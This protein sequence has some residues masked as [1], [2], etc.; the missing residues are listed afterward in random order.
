MH[1]K[2]GL[3][4]KS[5]PNNISIREKL[6]IA[7]ETGYDYLE[8]SIDET[9]EKQARLEWSADEIDALKDAIK[10]TKVPIKSI[11][12]SGHRK[13]PLGSRD[14]ATRKRSLEIMQK[15]ASLAA[16]LGI[17]IIQLAGYD[18]YYE[19]SGEDTVELFSKNLKTATEMAA[20]EGVLLGFETMETEFLNTV[21]KTM[22]W[23]DEVNSPYLQI[24]PD[25]GNL[26]NAAKI[27]ETDPVADLAKG[28]GHIVAIHLKETK[29]DV[30]REV[31]YGE[32]H[33]DFDAMC[34]QSLLMGVR[35]FV[36]EFW[37]TGEENWREILRENN[38][39]LRN[40]LNKTS[41]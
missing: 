41:S 12:L 9:D 23:V 10:E 6:E 18:V 24:Y 5:M 8:L 7:A 1:Y 32:G 16:Q 27:Y 30:Y 39:F 3:Y 37:Y 40:K 20:A 36:G 22:K 31:P 21:K 29:P 26:T 11:C 2:L 4:E 33:V 38:E 13:Y 35:M 25:I 15:A 17:A 34:K 28:A 14:E 19:E